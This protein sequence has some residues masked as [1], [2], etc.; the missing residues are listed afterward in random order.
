MITTEKTKIIKE[1]LSE[2]VDSFLSQ[3]IDNGCG[4]PFI[5]NIHIH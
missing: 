5:K 1:R 4:P 2:K 3:P